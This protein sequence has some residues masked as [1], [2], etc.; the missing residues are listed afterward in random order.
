LNLKS[1]G[2]LPVA[3]L[4][5]NPL[6]VTNIDTTTIRLSRDGFEEEDDP[7]PIRWNY[8][9]VLASSEAELY[10]HYHEGSAVGYA[11]LTLKFRTQAIVEAIGYVIDGEE[12]VLTIRGNLFDGT[13]FEGKDSV[14]IIKKGKK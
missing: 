14:R 4:G 3:I 7:C 13:Q 10:D 11:D 1:K 5:S 8:E 12:V 2:V 6:N 9:D